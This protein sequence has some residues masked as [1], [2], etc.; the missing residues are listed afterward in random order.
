MFIQRKRLVGFLEFLIGWLLLTLLGLVVGGVMGGLA[1]A[2]ASP[3]LFLSVLLHVGVAITPWGLGVLLVAPLVALLLT[4]CFA[5]VKHVLQK[6]KMVVKIEVPANV[7]Q[8]LVE[9]AVTQELPSVSEFSVQDFN[10]GLETSALSPVSIAGCESLT[11]VPE[12][13]GT[14]IQNFDSILGTH[15]PPQPVTVIQSENIAALR[16]E[17]LSPSPVLEP[18]TFAAVVAS[19]KTPPEKS[20]AK[21]WK[22]GDATMPFGRR[23]FSYD[24]NVSRALNFNSPLEKS[25]LTPQTEIENKENLS[26][27]LKQGSPPAP[28]FPPTPPGDFDLGSSNGSPFQEFDL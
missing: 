18:K 20:P 21:G 12:A 2:W 27:T 5:V 10:A 28:F 1:G 19:P 13:Q 24:P 3:A 9:E 17:E 11:T 14:P 16:V 15:T 22:S 7:N 4:S 6:R 25:P 26:G 23:L 8:V